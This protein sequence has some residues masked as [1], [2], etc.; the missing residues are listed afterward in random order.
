M[1]EKIDIVLPVYREEGNIAEVLRQIKERVKTPHRVL[2]VWQDRRDPTLRVLTILKKKMK[3]LELVE[4]K[5]GVGVVKALRTGYSRT[6]APIVVTMMAD[7]SD[8]AS[9]IDRM[10]ALMNKGYDVVA[11]SRYHRHGRRVGGP[12]MKGFLSHFACWTLAHIFHFPTTDATNAF[13]VFR[14][15]FLQSETIES[16]GGFELP[17]ELTV[18]AFRKGL[19]I[20]EVPTIWH[21]RSSGKSKFKLIEWLPQYLRWY[22]MAITHS[23]F[24]FFFIEAKRR[25]ISVKRSTRM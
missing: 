14:R 23:M 2:A 22:W 21:E 15:S 11:A 8:D 17:L 9:D 20:G 7:L 24:S 6:R 3:N 19:R 4:C 12:R 25:P 5:D 10:V 13:R 18:K 1:R 16:L